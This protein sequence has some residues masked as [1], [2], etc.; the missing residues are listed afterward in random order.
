MLRDSPAAA[1]Q[2]MADIWS[3]PGRRWLADIPG[4]STRFDGEM[5][6][7]RMCGNPVPVFTLAAKELWV[8][9]AGEPRLAPAPKGFHIDCE[10]PGKPD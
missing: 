7:Q 4:W 1:R 10:E 5:L 9:R 2:F 8:W 6:S 3:G